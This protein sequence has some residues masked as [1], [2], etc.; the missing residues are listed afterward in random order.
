M[1]SAQPVQPAEDPIGSGPAADAAVPEFWRSLG[2]PGLAD[3]HVHFLPP[4]VLAKVWAYFDAANVHY[5]VAWPITYRWG[6]VERAAYLRALGVRAFPALAYPHRPGMA[7]W[8][9]EWTLDFAAATAG[10]VPA[11]T[12]YP[13]PGVVDYVTAALDRGA[14]VFKAHIQVGEYDPADPLLDPVWGLLADAAVPVVTHCG[15]G[16]IPGRFTGPE[17]IEAVLRRH[18]HLTL[19]A[20]H[21]GAPQYEEHLALAERYPR[22]HLDTTMVGTDFMNRFAPFPSAALRPRLAALADR[23]VL[24]TDFPNI[25]YPYAHQLEALARWE[26]GDDWLR[27]V[28]WENGVRLLGIPI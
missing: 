28:L 20:A 7:A 19:V 23:I 5:G 8:L 25:P 4:R 9:N 11:A 12:F 16:P 24:G 18:P 21:L 13:E 26:L 1:K 17:R 27:R 2:L 22:V 14:R 10:C 15:G 6:D 3:I